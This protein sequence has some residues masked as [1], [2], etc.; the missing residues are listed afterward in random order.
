MSSPRGFA[1]GGMGA[2][3]REIDA[4]LARGLAVGVGDVDLDEVAAAGSSG[5]GKKKASGFNANLDRK[6][7]LRTLRYMLNERSA[8]FAWGTYLQY[9]FSQ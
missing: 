6:G 9:Y 8:R 4:D 7:G 5:L 3:G 1:A 2:I